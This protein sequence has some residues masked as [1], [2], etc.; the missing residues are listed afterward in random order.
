[1]NVIKGVNRRIIEISGT[2]NSC[3]EKAVLYVRPDCDISQSRLEAEARIYARQIMN[4]GELKEEQKRSDTLVRV[5]TISVTLL[6]IAAFVISAAL[7]F[8]GA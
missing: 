5:L 2:D 7:F 3:F 8:I 4:S 6:V 1:M